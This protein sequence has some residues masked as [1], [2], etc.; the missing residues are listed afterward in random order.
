MPLKLAFVSMHTSPAAQPGSG[1]AGG[2]NVVER[3]Q[4]EHLAKLGHRIELIT[5]RS[6]PDQPDI[7]ELS[8]GVFLR[9]LDGGPAA[10][11]AKSAIDAHIP[12]FSA[13]IGKL[14]GF[15][16]IHSHH[17]MSGVA[18]LPWAKTWGI[19]HVQ[20][21]HSVAALPNSGLSEGEPP[22][23]SA[24]VAG[25]AQ[26]ARESNA[27][28]AISAAEA[29]TVI[30]RC[31]A[32]PDRV[33]IIHPGVD[34]ALFHPPGVGQARPAAKG[35]SGYVLFAARLQPLKAPDLA[36]RALAEVPAQ[37]R[38]RLVVAGDVSED[39]RAYE[40]ELLALTASLNLSGQVDF[41][42]P[43][44]RRELARLMRGAQITLVPSYSET[45]GLVALEAQSSGTPV[46]ASSAG[47]LREAVAHR[48][49]GYL[50]DSREPADWGRAIV[51]L[52]SNAELLAAMGTVARVHARRFQWRWAALQLEDL[53]QKL[54]SQGASA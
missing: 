18:A 54:I 17:W 11:L 46:I 20:S 38:P 16:A 37:I 53:Y 15:D 44:Q 9:H 8:D 26:C 22:E 13:N 2:M 21:Y 43:L 3:A 28:V 7:V 48:E 23:S 40:A 33:H 41:T 12:Q 51:S 35:T 29:H 50:M 34:H 6:S 36:I 10:P 27:I 19:P 31:G 45:F 42:G 24:R 4:G 5:R 49:T 30:S 47:G 25:E 1:D 32:T 14:G 52:L 39:F